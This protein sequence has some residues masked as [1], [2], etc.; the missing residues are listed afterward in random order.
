M[1]KKLWIFIFATLMLAVSLSHLVS[2][3]GDGDDTD[4]HEANGVYESDAVSHWLGCKA[5]DE[6]RYGEGAHTYEGDGKIKKCSVCGREEEY[7]DEEN[8]AYWAEG[9]NKSKNTGYSYKYSTTEEYLDLIN[10]IIMG[11][12]EMTES[13]TE[14][15][16]YSKN[17]V[18]GLDRAGELTQFINDLQAL[19]YVSSVGRWKLYTERTSPDGSIQKD[20][21][22]KAPSFGVD[23]L[24]RYSPAAF[25]KE[26]CIGDGAT[27]EEFCT[28]FRQKYEE[29]YSDSGCTVS[30]MAIKKNDDGTVSFL[31]T[32][33]GEY[34]D[35][36]VRDSDYIKSTYVS[37]YDIVAGDSGIEKC[38]DISVYNSY[39]G[40]ET[41]NTS[42]RDTIT[43]CLENRFD[44]DTYDSI[45]VETDTTRDE[46]VGSISFVINGYLYNYSD[47]DRAI[48]SAYTL[49]EAQEH[50][51]YVGEN[52]SQPLFT[53][54]VDPDMFLIY[55]DEAK[56]NKFTS[57]TVDGE[58]TTL[59][60]DMVIPDG[61]AI[62]IVVREFGTAR[63][64]DLCYFRD[65]GGTFDTAKLYS[66]YPMIELDG[67]EVTDG[68]MTAVITCSESRI[69]T[70][71]Y[72]VY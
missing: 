4:T 25:V 13:A 27:F 72:K 71:V 40:D 11:K 12:R 20:G 43:T 60:V 64:I 18:Y 8:F 5:C 3:G 19:K 56:T 55:T 69:Y 35:G 51:A 57:M 2:C 62:V 58:S 37:D 29:M 47:E 22:Y 45:S 42:E 34:K 44:R 14:S 46:Y 63:G 48:G 7:T 24:C 32:A 21:V 59:Y 68:S 30:N 70:V 1:K 33:T 50:L 26:M 10:N 65:V 15:E 9:R 54:N 53:T 23:S 28:V 38:T 41:K 67:E 36:M 66:I 49:R 17:V 39:Y 6:H 61:K 16:Y 52:A 31:F